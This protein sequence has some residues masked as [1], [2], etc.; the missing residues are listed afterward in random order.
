ML[1]TNDTLKCGMQC[2]TKQLNE[3]K[4]KQPKKGATHLI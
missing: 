3:R 1:Q 4:Y 2:T